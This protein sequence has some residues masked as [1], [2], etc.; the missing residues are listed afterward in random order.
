MGNCIPRHGDDTEEL[1]MYKDCCGMDGDDPMSRARDKHVE[2][3]INA[4]KQ[5]IMDETFVV[6]TEELVPFVP[7]SCTQN[8]NSAL[9]RSGIA[10]V[11]RDTIPVISH[12]NC[13]Y[14]SKLHRTVVCV[15]LSAE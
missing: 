6:H 10:R 7:V 14:H 11:I 8:L 2:R 12:L 5:C 15:T 13:G 1:P 4:F 3:I 9:E